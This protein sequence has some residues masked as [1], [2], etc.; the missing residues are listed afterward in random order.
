MS[1]KNKIDSPVVRGSY[2]PEVERLTIHVSLTARPAD[3]ES[4]HA[5]ADLELT[6][7]SGDV[8][9][10]FAKRSKFL[11]GAVSEAM[12]KLVRDFDKGV[13]STLRQTVK[14]AKG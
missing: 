10:V 7:K 4:L 13:A 1:N 8:E 12:G 3:Y 5:G 2:D 11:R 6:C 9:Q 14:K